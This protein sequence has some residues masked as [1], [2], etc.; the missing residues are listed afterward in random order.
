MKKLI[1]LFLI[2]LTLCACFSGCV[3]TD[4]PDSTDK[5]ENTTN[6]SDEGSTVAH[7]GESVS[8]KNWK[9]TLQSAKTYDVIKSDYI[10]NKPAE[11]MEYLVLFFEVENLTQ[12]ENFF[13]YLYVQSYIDSYTANL[14]LILGDVEGY[15]I[16]SGNVAAGKKMKGCLVWEVGP[17]W[18]ELELSYKNDLFSME[19]DATFVVVPADVTK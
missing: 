15:E 3:V 18:E 8:S 6:G 4:N 17:N 9:I 16:L 5:V 11:G 19:K 12:K 2:V 1:C 7:V 13:N 10:E 14:K